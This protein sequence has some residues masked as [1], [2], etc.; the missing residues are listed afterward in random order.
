MYPKVIGS[1][2][3]IE[4]SMSLSDELL[5]AGFSAMAGKP[6][7]TYK[8]YVQEKSNPNS[9]YSFKPLGVDYV[10]ENSYKVTKGPGIEEDDPI[11]SACNG[12]VLV[13]ALD[14]NTYKIH[15][16]LYRETIQDLKA[17]VERKSGIPSDEQRLTL[18]GKQL[19]DGRNLASYNVQPH[20]T[21]HLTRRLRGGGKEEALYLDESLRA[22]SLDCDFTQQDDGGIEFYRGSKRYHR[23]CGWLRYA[24]NVLGKFSDDKWLGTP[25]YRTESAPGEWPVSYHGTAKS[26]ATNI[27]KAGYDLSKRERFLFGE[28]IYSAPSIDVA[29]RYAPD[30]QYD[31]NSYKIVFQNRVRGNFKVVSSYETGIGEYWVSSCDRDIRPYGICIKQT[32]ATDSYTTQTQPTSSDDGYCVL[33]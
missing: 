1:S 24:L 29:A 28:G 31:G 20:D 25:G 18:A 22:P 15:I 12:V 13:K 9:R 19:E 8:Q 11:C 23:P 6:V 4:S 26:N 3:Y 32:Q 10:M 7:L 16:C 14:G 27:A 21:I 5:A 2:E 33:L 17:L 30:Y